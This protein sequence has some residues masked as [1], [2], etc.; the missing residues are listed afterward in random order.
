MLKNDSYSFVGS[1][2]DYVSRFLIVFSVTDLEE[3]QDTPH[4][5]AFNNGSSWVVNGQGVL[6]LVDMTGRVLHQETLSGDQNHVNLNSFAK[7][8]YMLRLWNGDKARIQKI[9]LY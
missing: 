7:G 4:I 9:V 3:H 2:E 8:V 5:F 6:E 1:K